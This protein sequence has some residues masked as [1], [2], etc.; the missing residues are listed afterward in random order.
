MAEQKQPTSFK[1]MIGYEPE[2]YFTDKEI[3]L[4]KSTFKNNEAL[5]KLLRKVLLPTAF[6]PEL[7]IEQLKDDAW[8]GSLDFES[9]AVNEV[10]GIVAGRQNAIKFILG[11]LV[12]LKV[13]ANSDDKNPQQLAAIRQ[14]NSSK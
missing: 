6:D 14:A 11:G 9:M 10:K 13:M 2:A 12:K 3:A 8:M 1:E 7:P 5:I 4:A